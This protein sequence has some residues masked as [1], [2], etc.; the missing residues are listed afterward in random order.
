MPINLGPDEDALDARWFSLIRSNNN[1]IVENCFDKVQLKQDG[2]AHS[3]RVN[4]LK[5]GTYN[6]DFVSGH[7]E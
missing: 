5:Q 7:T 4:D 1:L 6:L 3:F 2:L